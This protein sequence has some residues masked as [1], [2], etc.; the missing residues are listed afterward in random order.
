MTRSVLGGSQPFPQ[1][2]RALQ[3]PCLPTSIR[4]HKTKPN[5]FISDFLFSLSV[6]S[7]DFASARLIQYLIPGLHGYRTAFTPCKHRIVTSLSISN[8]AD[9]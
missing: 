2:I 9:M 3:L 8:Y 7:L 5:K 6:T 4:Q 1:L